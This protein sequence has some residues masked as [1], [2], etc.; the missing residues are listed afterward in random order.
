MWGANLLLKDYV[1]FRANRGLCTSYL[2]TCVCTEPRRTAQGCRKTD[3]WLAERG[4]RK[5][6]GRRLHRSVEKQMCG[7]LNGGVEKQKDVNVEKQMDG[8]QGC[9]SAEAVKVNQSPQMGTAG[10]ADNLR[11]RCAVA[12]ETG[13]KVLPTYRAKCAC[14]VPYVLGTS[15]CTLC[16]YM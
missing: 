7:W 1:C 10:R 5:K 11:S 3:V 14:H 8:P 4:C 13:L 16:T 12:G 15:V 2:Y 9:R 6:D